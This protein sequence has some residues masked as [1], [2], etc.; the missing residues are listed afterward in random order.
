M[1]EVATGQDKEERIPTGV[2]GFDDLIEGGLPKG[3]NVLLTGMPGTGKTIFAL[4][5]L[6]EG[7]KMGENGLYVS[8]ES[9]PEQLKEQGERFGWDLKGME[10]A[11]KLF[12]LKVP[13][14]KI[15]FDIFEVIAKI[16]NEI[17]AKRV[18]LDNLA[19]FAIN[20][21]FFSITPDEWEG[22]DHSP[23]SFPIGGY[24]GSVSGVNIPGSQTNIQGSGYDKRTVYLI[25]ERMGKLGTTNL[26]ITYGNRRSEHL[27][28][29]GVSE[30]ACDGIIEFYNEPIGA[31]RIRTLAVLKMRA[32]K[33]S[34][35]VHEFELGDTGI[36]VKP[37]EQVYK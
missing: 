2:E 10:T 11:G 30:F 37:A 15:K 22:I 29:D 36:V 23:A 31:K 34:P 3:T 12:F 4:K 1:A 27:T 18:V 28:F 20:A 26:I 7:A 19:M 16:K 14:G 24:S 25:I 33:Q 32:T 13:L 9:S 35:Y 17:S 8:I 5:Y 6:Y 21:G